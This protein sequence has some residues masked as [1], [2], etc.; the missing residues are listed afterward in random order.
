[1]DFVYRDRAGQQVLEDV[2]GVITA[3]FTIKRHLLKAVH[4]LEVRLIR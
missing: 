4:G 2:K 1:V 3:A